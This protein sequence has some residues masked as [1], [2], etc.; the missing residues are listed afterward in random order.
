MKA[1]VVAHN[2]PK[3]LIKSATN[4]TGLRR[5]TKMEIGINDVTEYPRIT[6]CKEKE[7]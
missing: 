5:M 7:L 4:W 3:I 1:E 6:E 2:I